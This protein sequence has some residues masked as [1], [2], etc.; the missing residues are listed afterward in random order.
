MGH[1]LGTKD[2]MG[3]MAGSHHKA[4]RMGRKVHLRNNQSKFR[5]VEH[6]VQKAM[7]KELQDEN[8]N[9]K[10]LGKIHKVHR[11]TDQDTLPD[12]DCK[13]CSHLPVHNKGC[14]LRGMDD[15]LDR[16]Q[17]QSVIRMARTL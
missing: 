14:T 11:G 15:R 3:W 2:H 5:K 1:K 17:V 4:L 7:Q 8:K 6:K 12:K 9:W 13:G 16:I 10:L